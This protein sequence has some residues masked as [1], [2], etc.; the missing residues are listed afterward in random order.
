MRTRPPPLEWIATASVV[1]VLAIAGCGDSESTTGTVASG[2]TTLQQLGEGEVADAFGTCNR[3]TGR[4][5]T[6]PLPDGFLDCLR[7]AGVPEEFVK[8]FE[9]A[10]PVPVE[11]GGGVRPQRR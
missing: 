7:E 3:E 8:Q 5:E 4:T 2:T 10:E 1:S 9:S 6:N 11:D